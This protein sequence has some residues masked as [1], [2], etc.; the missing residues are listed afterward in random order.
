MVHPVLPWAVVVVCAEVHKQWTGPRTQGF[1]TQ[2]PCLL[3]WRVVPISPHRQLP[4]D[5]VLPPRSAWVLIGL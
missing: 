4:P 2:M 3:G 5:E 1:F